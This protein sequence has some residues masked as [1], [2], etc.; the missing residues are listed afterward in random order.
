MTNDATRASAQA[1]PEINRRRMLMGMATIPTCGLAAIVPATAAAVEPSIDELI[2][3]HQ[4]GLKAALESKFGEK[5]WRMWAVGP[6][7]IKGPSIF[8]NADKT[9]FLSAN[10]EKGGEA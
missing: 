1:M 6:R 3:H 10:P 8:F 4:T 2:E 7:G 5:T 9:V